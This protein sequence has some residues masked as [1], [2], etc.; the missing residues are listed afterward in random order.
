MTSS[1]SGGGETASAKGDFDVWLM[2][3]YILVDD[4]GAP[5]TEAQALLGMNMSEDCAYNAAD[6]WAA[7]RG[8]R[9]EY[10]L[11]WTDFDEEG[12]DIDDEL[13]FGDEA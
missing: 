1:G 10:D 12:P 3:G 6:I 4:R 13:D 5:P 7:E 8:A 2:D 9:I 11:L